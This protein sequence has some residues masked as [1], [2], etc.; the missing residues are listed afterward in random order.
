MRADH[1]KCCLLLLGYVIKQHI[2]SAC[3]SAYSIYETELYNSLDAACDVDQKIPW[4]ALRKTRKEV[5]MLGPS[6][7]PI[8]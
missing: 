2:N 8:K 1:A 7:S 6:K 5:A 4:S 3:L